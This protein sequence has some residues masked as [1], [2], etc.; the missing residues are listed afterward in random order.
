MIEIKPLSHCHAAVTIPGSKSYTHR[1]LILS[2]L[3]DGESVLINPLRSEDT[4]YTAQG[5]GKFGVPIFWEGD[6]IRVLGKGGELQAGDE[7]IDVGNSGTSMRFLTALA[8]LKKGR[9]LLDGS[10]RMRRRPISGLLEGLEALGGRAYSQKGDGFPPV[11]VES[12]VLKGGKAKI[13]SE[14]SSQFLSALLMIAPFASENVYMEV[15]GNLASR[16]YVDITLDMMAAF[17]VEVQMEGYR[18]FSVRAGQHYHPRKYRIEGDASNASYFFS[19]AAVSH[20]RVRVENFNPLS[21]QGDAGFLDILESMG[22][23]VLRGEGWAEVYGRELQGIEIDMNEMP[24]LVPT[25]A[26]TAAFTRGE[27]I[28]RNIGHLRHKESDRIMTLAQGLDKMGVKVEEGEDWLKIGGGKPHGAEIETYDDHRL[29]MSFAIAGLAVPGVK[30]KEERC[31]DKSFPGFW[32]EF[33]K[34]Y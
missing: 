2:A 27:T 11:V 14:E 31:V 7:K 8:V 32:E 29:A 23:V 18:S 10:D 25:L 30:I 1:A 15:E 34:L 3:A 17:G 4:V 26:V 24:D 20:G 28:I 13:M 19:A 21:I 5:L 33:Q 16:P 6:F 12:R 22:C 9:T